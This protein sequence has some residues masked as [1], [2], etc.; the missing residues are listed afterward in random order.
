MRREE[1]DDGD[2]GVRAASA[3][4]YS[5]ANALQHGDPTPM[6][7]LWS[8]TDDTT[9]CTPS[10]TVLCG[11]VELEGYWRDAALHIA[12]TPERLSAQ[13]D[14]ITDVMAGDL[15]YTITN[16]TVRRSDG[17]VLLVARATNVYRLDDGCWRLVHRHADA[18]PQRP[19]EHGSA[20]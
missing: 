14:Y 8:H 9:Y 12:G 7:A 2:A 15:A 1:A 17:S 11:C 18:A 3:R 20:R 10:G 16:E 4:F 19:A 13:G 5:A 6:L